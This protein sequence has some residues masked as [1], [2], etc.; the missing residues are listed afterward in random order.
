MSYLQD[1]PVPD[2][3]RG[4]PPRWAAADERAWAWGPFVVER[5]KGMHELGYALQPANDPEAP[6]WDAYSLEAQD[7]VIR[8]KL[9]APPVIKGN[10]MVLRTTNGP[11]VFRPLRESDRSWITCEE[12]LPIVDAVKRGMQW[13]LLP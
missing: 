2:A 7:R 1:A 3:L 8:I 12:G 9:E 5:G 13:G 10:V 4:D 11:M 6:G